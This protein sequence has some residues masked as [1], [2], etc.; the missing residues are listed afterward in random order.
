MT[1]LNDL[2]ILFPH[3]DR[4]EL[5]ALARMI[6]RESRLD[7][8]DLAMRAMAWAEGMMPVAGIDLRE[9]ILTGQWPA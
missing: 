8:M 4:D 5:C 6:D 7:P 9:R 1:N 3:A 2:R